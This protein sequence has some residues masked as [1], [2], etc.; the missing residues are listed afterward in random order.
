[1]KINPVLSGFVPGADNMYDLGNKEG[2]FRAIK[3]QTGGVRAAGLVTNPGL[4]FTSP[5][6]IDSGYNRVKNGENWKDYILGGGE[7]LLGA[8]PWLFK[9][10]TGVRSALSP[11]YRLAYNMNKSL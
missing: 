8:A 2:F 7:M 9:G 1:M 10:Y 6:V 5:T 4:I 3:G 11:K